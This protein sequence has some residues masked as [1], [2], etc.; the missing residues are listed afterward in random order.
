MYQ[1]RFYPT[2]PCDAEDSEVVAEFRSES[3][4]DALNYYLTYL[5][6]LT[7]TYGVIDM[8]VAGGPVLLD[9]RTVKA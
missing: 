3:E 6:G 2:I 7:G 4:Y 5:E 8:D 9:V 1:I